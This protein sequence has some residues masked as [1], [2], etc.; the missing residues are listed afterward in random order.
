MDKE[1]RQDILIKICCIVASLALWIYIRS[2]ENP[3]TSHTLKYVPV[4]IINQEVLAQSDLILVP[5][6]EPTVN[7]NIKGQTSSIDVIDKNRDFKIIAD[8]SKY[9]LK[10]GENNIPVEIKE[11]QNNVTITNK[12]GIT[13][14]VI[15]DTLTS[16][17]VS[18]APNIIGT[19][20]EGF[21]S[22]TPIISPQTV[23]ISGGKT[24]VDRVANIVADIDITNANVDID[25]TIKL[26]AV[27]SKGKDVDNVTI[28]PE[29][30]Q[31]K[32]PI[33]KGK[34]VD[35]E[36]RTFGATATGAAVETLEAIPKRVEVVGNNDV[37]N[38]LTS[39]PTEAIDLSKIN[40]D[41][42]VDVK[43]VLPQGVRLTKDV[44]TVKVKVSLKKSAQKTF[45]VT[46]DN[47]N[48]GKDFAATLDK[49]VIEVVL[50]GP[51]SEMNKIVENT[52][53]ASVDLKDLGEGDHNV[54]VV[55][56][57]IPSTL[58]KVSQSFATVKATIKKT[59]EVISNNVN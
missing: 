49:T 37:I 20:S 40:G 56:A 3:V 15:L 4:Q 51:E 45:K 32:V 25:K 22:D 9:A 18:V 33:K 8:L 46:I 14:K 41:T 2:N 12:E 17:E 47:K 57:G 50:A 29:Y 55:V 30:A 13:V 28:S 52:L 5:D 54:N 6:Q 34:A 26:K 44:A 19:T 23:V 38:N 27:D 48:L 43:L 35:I 39:I 59:S 42:T 10:A 16:K 53:T 1:K 31:V 36:V 24:F 58:Q 7:I 11:Q 21:Y